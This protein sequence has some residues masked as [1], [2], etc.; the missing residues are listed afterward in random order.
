MMSTEENSH[1]IGHQVSIAGQVSDQETGQI[2]SGAI[3]EIT[4]MP[5]T[6]KT[7]LALRALQY[8]TNWDTLPKRPDRA[9]TAI[10]GYF[11]FIDLPDGEYTL[12]A[13][14]PGASNR[15]DSA[16]IKVSLTTPKYNANITLPPSGIKG[17]LKDKEGHFIGR[18][19]VQIQGSGEY[20]FSDDEGKYLLS[21]LEAPKDKSKKRTVNMSIFAQGYTQSDVTIEFGLGEMT[22]KNCSLIPL[23]KPEPQSR[24][25]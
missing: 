1:K 8:G 2:I 7:K 14:L 21:G 22:E 5:E 11:Y 9:I 15:Y 20:T 10:D 13:T 25:E 4:A 23:S 18:A 16:E 19:K 24:S 12:K 6:F 3:V 17:Q